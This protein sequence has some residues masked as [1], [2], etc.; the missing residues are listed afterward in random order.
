MD[1]EFVGFGDAGVF[2]ALARTDSTNFTF[3]DTSF[4]GAYYSYSASAG[5][6]TSDDLYPRR[7]ADVTGDH[8]ADIL[9][10]GSAGV[11]FSEFHT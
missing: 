7:A 8:R 6:W 10:F 4:G 3:G 2:Y 5:G 11:Y 1:G 9:G